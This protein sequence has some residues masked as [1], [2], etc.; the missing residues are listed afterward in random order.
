[1]LYPRDPARWKAGFL[2]PLLRQMLNQSTVYGWMMIGGI[3]LGLGFWWRL[4]R[5]DSRLLLIY[6]GALGGAFLGAK[7][8]YLAAEGW[9][10]WHETNRWLQLATGKSITGGLM[11]GYVGVEIAKRLLGYGRVTG[12]FFAL[13]TPIGISLGRIGCWFHGCCRGIE[14][15]PAWF[16]VSDPQ[17][18]A[19][20]PSVQVEILFNVVALGGA[21]ALRKG[22]LLGNQHFH[23]YLMAYGAFRFMH[24]FMRE[25]PRIF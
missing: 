3:L 6:L 17:G 20:W 4:A 9:M 15:S 1:M 24:E 25:T 21:L 11:G 14:C 23:L 16:T 10:H 2:L 12:D 22:R 5:R 7:L 13:I 19:R 8:A 18:V